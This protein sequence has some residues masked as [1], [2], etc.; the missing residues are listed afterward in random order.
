[1]R[2]NQIKN[3]VTGRQGRK[4]VN[5]YCHCCRYWYISILVFNRETL[6]FAWRT[7]TV[8][9]I[10]C[11][12]ASLQCLWSSQNQQPYR[13]K[14]IADRD[15]IAFENSRKITTIVFDKQ[16]LT[17]GTL[18]SQNRF[19]EKNLLKMKHSHCICIEQQ[20]EHLLQQVFYLKQRLICRYSPENF[21]AITG[22]VLSH[23]GR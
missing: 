20:S 7:V 9:V 23:R 14:R 3:P 6:A 10:C 22:K 15:R 11:P 19:P 5:H 2:K 12:H 21:K 18:K 16:A 4:M 1:M 17:V 8:I 13:Q